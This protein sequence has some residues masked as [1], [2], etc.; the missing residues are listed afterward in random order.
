VD[1]SGLEN[2]VTVEAADGI[3]VSGLNN[4]VTFLS[5]DPELIDSGLGN[6]VQPG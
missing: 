6:T 3:V 2:T 1:V 5:G 4:K